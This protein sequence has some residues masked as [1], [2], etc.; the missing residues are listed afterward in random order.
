M[1]ADFI[2]QIQWNVYP[3]NVSR[4]RYDLKQVKVISNHQGFIF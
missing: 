3:T 1:G 4:Y 2:L